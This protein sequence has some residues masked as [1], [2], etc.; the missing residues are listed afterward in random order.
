MAMS[1]ALG[2]SIKALAIVALLLSGLAAAQDRDTQ[3]VQAYVLT[4]AGLAKY[5]QATKKL[6]ALSGG[7]DECGDDDEGS[8]SLDAMTAKL[9]AN[10]AAKSAI[11]SAGMTT[12]EYVVFTWSLM[13]NGLAA[14]AVSQ[15]GGKLPAGVSKANVDFY[16]KN[17]AAVQQLQGAG[18]D[19]DCDDNRGED[20]NEE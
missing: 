15:P 14:W 5:T 8:Q 13:Q 10:P 18:D 7:S 12:R 9:N 20:E 4:D 16:K 11:A 17:E 2:R 1:R 6:A 19:A 3:E